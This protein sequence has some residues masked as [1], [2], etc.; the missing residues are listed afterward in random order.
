MKYLKTLIIVSIVFLSGCATVTVAEA[1]PREFAF[2]L[3]FQAKY[4]FKPD[5]TT[6]LVINQV[7]L[8]KKKVNAKSL[9]VMRAGAFTAIKFAGEQLDALPHMKIINLVDSVSFNI[10]TDSIK[11]LAAKY[12]SDYTL[13]LTDYT[14]DVFAEGDYGTQPNYYTY[15]NV[16][17]T[18]FEGNGTFYKKLNGAAT[19]A[20]SR[21]PNES[22]L[23]SLF[24]HPT[25]IKNKDSV[26]LASKTAALVALRDY[27]P[28]SETVKRPLYNDDDLKPMVDEIFAENFSKADTLSRPIINGKDLIMAA[29]AAYN[30]AVVCEAQGDFEEAIILARRSA[31]KYKNAY[32]LE[33]LNDL[34]SE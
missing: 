28:H 14:A 26:N 29:K 27:V 31:A 23:S 17:F 21:R 2:S 20:Q 9:E 8:S 18:L 24:V 13:A 12:H 16:K 30:M 4:S 1:Q 22:V 3:D 7:D 25:L 34:K 10:S 33:L 11:H 32:A 5:T 6:L 15:A 19:L